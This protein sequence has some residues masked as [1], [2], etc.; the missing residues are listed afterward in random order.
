MET[1]MKKIS[2]GLSLSFLLFLCANF[3]VIK[4]K[5]SKCSVSKNNILLGFWN[6]EF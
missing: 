2:F 4:P 6:D 5:L 1:D 3:P